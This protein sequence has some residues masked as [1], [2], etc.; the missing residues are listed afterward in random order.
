M[1]KPT[2][3]PPCLHFPPPKNSHQSL[4]SCMGCAGS[5]YG[6]HRSGNA[7]RLCNA[8]RLSCRRRLSCSPEHDDSSASSEIQNYLSPARH[9][10][11][12]KV[13]GNTERHDVTSPENL[14]ENDRTFSSAQITNR[15][16]LARPLT[17]QLE[18]AR[19]SA[20]RGLSRSAPQHRPLP[21]CASADP[22]RNCPGCTGAPVPG[23]V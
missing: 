8:Q 1:N 22:L 21:Q 17:Y 13:R 7:K 9:G 14:D 2:F 12:E 16:R 4:D 15:V 3:C 18:W 11:R 19:F 10:R 20:A 6:H 5:V 23:R